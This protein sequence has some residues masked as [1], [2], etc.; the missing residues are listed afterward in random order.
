LLRGFSVIPHIP[1]F[2]KKYGL[3][4]CSI[5]VYPMYRGITRLLG[6]ETLSVEGDIKR[7][8]RIIE[9]VYQTMIFISSY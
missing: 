7:G 4:A 2:D 5:A 3:K 8:D 1:S 6:M 9:K